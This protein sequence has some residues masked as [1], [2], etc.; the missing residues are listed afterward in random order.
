MGGREDLEAGVGSVGHG[1][2]VD[3]GAERLTEAINGCEDLEAAVGS[4]GHGMRAELGLRSTVLCH[5]H[6]RQVH[7]HRPCSTS[8]SVCIEAD[9]SYVMGQGA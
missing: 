6:R 9:R 7:R 1:W 2:V 4:D 3:L 5:G 8:S